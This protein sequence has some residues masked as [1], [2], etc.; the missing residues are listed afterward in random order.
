MKLMKYSRCQNCGVR[1]KQELIYVNLYCD[2]CWK[3]KRREEIKNYQ[4]GKEGVMK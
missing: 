2:K 3:L 1:F 4:D